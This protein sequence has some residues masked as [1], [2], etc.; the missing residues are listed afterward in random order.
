MGSIHNRLRRVWQT[1]GGRKANFA[2]KC[3]KAVV[4]AMLAD[5]FGYDKYELLGQPK[6]FDSIYVGTPLSEE[7]LS[8][9]YIPDAEINRHGI[10]PDFLIR[11]KENGKEI[12]IEIKRQDGWVEG[13]TRHDGRGNAHERLC[14]YFTPG[15]L[16][17]LRQ[18]GGVEA[19]AL[20]FVIVFVGDITRDICRV[21]EIRF[22]FDGNDDNVFFW[23]DLADPDGLVAHLKDHV[24]PLLD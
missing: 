1:E 20:P 23:R 5:E 15:L 14:K 13:K 21:R 7:E 22:W 17:A 11:N 10:R 18:R 2:E 12:Y 19:P 6:V 16:K 3:Y 4:E 9:I 8:M 24:L